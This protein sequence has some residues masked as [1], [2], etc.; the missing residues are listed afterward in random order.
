MYIKLQDCKKFLIH[1]DILFKMLLIVKNWGQ[2][3]FEV[4]ILFRRFPLIFNFDMNFQFVQGQKIM[5]F[6]QLS[7]DDYVISCY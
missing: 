7:F 2:K 1:A 3:R 4:S 5:R 6:L